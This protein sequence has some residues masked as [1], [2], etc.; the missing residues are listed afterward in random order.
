MRPRR[1]RNKPLRHRTCAKARN[2]GSRGKRGLRPGNSLDRGARGTRLRSAHPFT[3]STMNE[4]ETLPDEEL[5][6][7]AIEWRRRALQGDL[8]AAASRINWRRNCGDALVR[9]ILTTTPWIFGRLRIG[10]GAGV[11]GSHGE[12]AFRVRAASA[13]PLLRA[14][15]FSHLSLTQSSHR[16]Q[17]LKLLRLPTP[18]AQLAVVDRP[19]GRLRQALHMLQRKAPA[20]RT[21]RPIVSRRTGASVPTR[22][23]QSH[24]TAATGT[25]RHTS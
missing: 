24:D 14:Q 4:T 9:P 10:R 2:H 11:G 1:Q 3:I 5:G 20:S 25:L 7:R 19:T 16:H 17:A 12:L 6:A 13:T 15:Q 21:V 22:P 23:R 8:H 18:L